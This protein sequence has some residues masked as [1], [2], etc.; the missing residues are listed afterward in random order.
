MPTCGRQGARSV[1]SSTVGNT[2]WC[3]Q[4]SVALIVIS[5]SS[6]SPKDGAAEAALAKPHKR[7]V[8]T[9][10]KR[11]RMVHTVWQ[12]RYRKDDSWA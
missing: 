8:L 6:L 12:W 3:R 11:L 1:F 10:E 9:R 7:S 4:Q 2:R 5:S